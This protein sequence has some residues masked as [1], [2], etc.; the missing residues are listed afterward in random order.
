M[1]FGKYLFTINLLNRISK[2]AKV[3][4]GEIQDLQESIPT[5]GENMQKR[6]QELKQEIIQLSDQIESLRKQFDVISRLKTAVSASSNKHLRARIN[7]AELVQN[8]LELHEREV[9]ETTELKMIKM[10]EIAQ[11]ES[12]AE[13]NV[14]RVMKKIQVLQ[15]ELSSLEREKKCK[16]NKHKLNLL[17][18]EEELKRAESRRICGELDVEKFQCPLCLGILLAGMKIFQ[19]SA[20]HITCEACK[21]LNQ[22]T[23]PTC[24][25][26][27]TKNRACFSRN[28]ALETVI[29]NNNKNNN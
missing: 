24:S 2:R 18:L 15:E 22:P 4:V 19:C 6:F 10:K 26:C 16:T 29:S 12:E 3:L 21:N 1:S 13:K 7:K 17:D 14:Q 20:G 11:C 9:K 23:P 25:R 8:L 5:I 28:R 27:D